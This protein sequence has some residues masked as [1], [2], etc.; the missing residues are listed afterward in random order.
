MP[1]GGR[2][3][4]AG[5]SGQYNGD[6]QPGDVHGCSGDDGH[7]TC[8]LSYISLTVHTVMA[9]LFQHAECVMRRHEILNIR[10]LS[11]F[12][13]FVL[14]VLVYVFRAVSPLEVPPK[15]VNASTHSAHG[16]FCPAVLCP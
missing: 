6:D 15:M 3:A 7:N 14:P 13:L 12:L 9:M 5:L 4:W 10:L 11:E 16:S 8:F 2:T 1:S